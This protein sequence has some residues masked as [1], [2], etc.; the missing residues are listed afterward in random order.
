M[1]QDLYN[2][3]P[4]FLQNMACSLY[5]YKENRKRYGVYFK[6]MLASLSKTEWFS[7][8]EI[9]H[10]QNEQ[11]KRL[12][13]HA[14]D[15]VPYYTALFKSQKLHPDDIQTIHDLDKIP[16]LTK[17]I[18]RQQEDQLV[19]TAFKKQRLTKSKT[20]GSTGKAVTIYREVNSLQFH[21]AL[22]WRLRERFGIKF[23]QDLLHLN[24]TGRPVV[25][26]KNRKRPFWR[27]NR[28]F[29]QYLLPMQ[30]IL[31]SAIND[32]LFF[33]ENI[34]FEYYIGYPS[35]INNFCDMLNEKNLKLSKFPKF[36]FSGC[37]KLYDFQKENIEQTLNTSVK[38]QY[39]MA[40]GVGNATQCE[41]G[42]YH[43]DF[44]HGILNISHTVNSCSKQGSV[45]GT[46]FSNYAMPLINYEV[47]DIAILG[48]G[49]CPCGRK[50]KLFS[51][52]E[53][54]HEDYVITPEGNHI[55]RFDYLFKETKAIKEAQVQ[56]HQLG[57]IVI[58]LVKTDFYNFD[59]EK[60]LRKMVKEWISPT[61][62]VNFNYVDQIQ[63]TNTGKFRAVVS[64]L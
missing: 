58:C 34:Q 30:Q 64:Y 15:T 24:F 22:W 18:L 50:S 11:V 36:I 44:E 9:E 10:Y 45:I 8:T 33:L 41:F 32:I 49:E 5:G 39:G 20:S 38:D 52:F 7:K 37:E 17:D 13:A 23:E 31:P 3:S 48:D 54:R 35:I 4:V 26:T 29:N 53:G 12:V 42:N 27:Y 14:Y 25:P 16:I 63:R 21:W 47:G 40:E 51:S 28:A 19:S 56:Q 46:G 61:L 6:Q 60:K 55:M 2:I 59:I 62:K 43:E 1:I 57:E